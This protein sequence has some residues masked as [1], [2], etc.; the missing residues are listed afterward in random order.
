MAGGGA[1]TIS[2]AK[3]AA[4]EEATGREREW[5]EGGRQVRR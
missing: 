4:T 1:E 5:R 3:F 2:T